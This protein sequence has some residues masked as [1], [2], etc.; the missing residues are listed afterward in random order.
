MRGSDIGQS[1]LRMLPVINYSFQ[2]IQHETPDWRAMQYERNLT[3]DK[4]W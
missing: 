4:L 3:E 1:S 2:H